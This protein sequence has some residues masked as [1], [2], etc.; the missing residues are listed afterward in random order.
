MKF[1]HARGMP[2]YV[3]E[4]PGI[5]PRSVHVRTF[6]FSLYSMDTVVNA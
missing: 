5:Q 3:S 2:A 6:G 1:F 4:F